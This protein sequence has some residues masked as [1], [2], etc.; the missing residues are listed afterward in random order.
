M[1]IN[2]NIINEITT[3]NNPDVVYVVGSST[4]VNNPNDVDILILY[5]N[6]EDFANFKRSIY[7][8][9]DG[10]RYEVFANSLSGHQQN[11]VNYAYGTNGY[12]KP[13][14]GTLSKE[15]LYSID[16]LNNP[17]LRDKV[18]NKLFSQYYEYKFN[19]LTGASYIQKPY[20]FLLTVYFIANNSYELTN[21][22]VNILNMVHDKKTM[23]EDLWLY[24]EKILFKELFN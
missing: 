7:Y 20:R 13:I 22:Q 23:S 15:E 1:H 6:E 3:N 17:T 4:V 12:Y 24:C 21:E 14:Y 19:H 18:A 8:D 5:R 9:K 2:N 11:V 10:V 16:F